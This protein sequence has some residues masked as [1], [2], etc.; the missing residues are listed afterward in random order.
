M[1]PLKVAK[2]YESLILK[3][4]NSVSGKSLS[5]EGGEGSGKG[6][7]IESLKLIFKHYNFNVLF[8]REPGGVKISEMIR[9]VIVDKSNTE[10]TPITE[11]LLYAASRNQHLEEK[12]FP[13]LNQGKFVIFDR[14][15]D[16]SYVYQG[17][18]RGVGL[19][20]VILVNDIA[21]KKFLPKKTIILDI[22]PKIGLSRINNNGR[23]TNRLDLESIEFH[24]KIRVGYE[25]LQKLYPDRI[26]IIDASKSPSEVLEDTLK[27]ILENF[28]D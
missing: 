24:E 20:T 3:L 4:K 12:V 6:T 9:D 26:S 8:T 13:A 11:M 28:I 17:F 2:K 14:F 19:E 7:L 25:K 5:I 10:M 1:E 18:S 27:I 21:T 16:S 22:D 15:V 23:E